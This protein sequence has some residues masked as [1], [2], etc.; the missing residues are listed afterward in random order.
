MNFRIITKNHAT[1]S[2]MGTPNKSILEPMG[3]TSPIQQP[4]G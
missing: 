3:L 4:E 2:K 1:D